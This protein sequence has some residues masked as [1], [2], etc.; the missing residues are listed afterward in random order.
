MLQLLL[1]F[2][3]LPL[4]QFSNDIAVPAAAKAD[5]AADYHGAREGCSKQWKDWTALPKT[6]ASYRAKV[7]RYANPWGLLCA[8]MQLQ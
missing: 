5:V 6:F 1:L 2:L 8:I 3:A 4:P 7:H